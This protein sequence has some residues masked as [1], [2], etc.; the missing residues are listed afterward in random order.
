MTDADEFVSEAARAVR[1]DAVFEATDPEESTEEH[2]VFTDVT[3]PFRATVGLEDAGDTV[4]Y[5]VIIEVPT[6]NAAVA[7]EEVAPVVQEGWLE[8]FELRLEDVT[9]VTKTDPDAPTVVTDTSTGTVTV[10]TT[11]E[12]AIPGRGVEDTKAVINYVEGT[13]MEGIIPGYEYDEP[14]KG[15]LDRARER[16]GSTAERE[17]GGPPL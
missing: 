13:Y 11:F 2:P 10:R 9:G 17:S 14:V 3:S 1:D 7:D 16:S 12:T 8:T 6:L 5:T 15:L 4:A